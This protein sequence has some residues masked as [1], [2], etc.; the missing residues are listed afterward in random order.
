MPKQEYKSITVSEVVYNHFNEDY[1]KSKKYLDMKGV[2]SFSGYVAYML[3]SR[4]REDEALARYAPPIT[5]I[6]VDNDRVVVLDSMKNRIAEVV[7]QNGELYCQ[8]CRVDDCLH[9]GFAYALPEVNMVLSAY[10]M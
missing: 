8:L 10:P 5:K 7:V 4:I 6:S 3:E 9:V 1:L 2:R